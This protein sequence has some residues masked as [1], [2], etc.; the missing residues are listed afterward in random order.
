[1]Y[2]IRSYYAGNP[3]PEGQARSQGDH[4]RE[5]GRD[6]RGLGSTGTGQ[7]GRFKK[8]IK[9]GLA[10]THKQQRDDMDETPHECLFL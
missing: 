7:R 10:Q 9:T 8:K 3:F 6:H 4:Q 5:H 1:M 2:A